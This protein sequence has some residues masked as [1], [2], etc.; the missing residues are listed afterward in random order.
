MKSTKCIFISVSSPIIIRNFFLI[1]NGVFD[2][3]KKRGLKIVIL[4]TH[5]AYGDVKKDLGEEN[6]IIEPIVIS[7]HGNFLQRV[8]T[9]MATYLNFTEGARLFASMGVRIDIPAAGGRNYL[10][11]LKLFISN[12]LGKSKFVR[13]YIMPRIDSLVY[14]KRPYKEIFDRHKPDFVFVPDV[15]S[16]QDVTVIREARRQRI[17]TIGMPGSWDHFPKKFEPLRADKLMVWNEVNKKE[18]IELQDYKESDI[19]VTGAS[20]YDIFTYNKLL[21]SRNEFLS[22]FG[23]D[24]NRKIIFF[25]SGTKYSPY[26]G[27]TVDIILKFVKENELS[28][29]SQIFL[30][31]YPGVKSDHDKFDKFAGEKFIYTDWIEPKKI[32]GQSAHAWYP[33]FDSIAHF[34]NCIYHA[35]IIVNAYSSVSV[36]ASVYLKPIINVNFDGYQNPPF[37]KSIRR[38]Q[39]YSHYKHVLK[40][41]GVRQVENKNELL[42]AIN[43]FLKD[44]KANKD[45]VKKLRDKMCWKVDGKAGERIAHN[46][47]KFLS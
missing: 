19:I 34:L 8:Y 2:L 36:E 26:D 5:Q 7:W 42:E 28:V 23:L 14:R 29:P 43:E 15:H 35:D 20:F 25:A 27:D 44:P 40:T 1:P 16:M 47:L 39:H 46:I 18:A 31:P 33:N 13:D 30:R 10:Y 21:M 41:K 12:T 38:F 9:F 37:S 3:L 22:K 4:V 24:K 11:Y 17:M 6:V 32:F 45:N